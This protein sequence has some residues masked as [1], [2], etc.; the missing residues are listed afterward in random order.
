MKA[1]QLATVS[2]VNVLNREKTDLYKLKVKASVRNAAGVD[3]DVAGT[4][5]AD[6]GET[7]VWVSVLDTNDLSPMFFPAEYEVR[8]PSFYR[9]VP[10]FSKLGFN[11]FYWLFWVLL[12]FT[13]FYWVLLGFIGFYWVLLGFIGFYW[14]LLG[15][16][17]YYQVLLEF[18]EFNR[19]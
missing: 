6:A 12:G 9:V 4:G 13:G 14:V 3:E 17:G 7:D 8:R 5:D 1:R 19:D 2:Q 18:S 16:T 11:R 15:F 10:T